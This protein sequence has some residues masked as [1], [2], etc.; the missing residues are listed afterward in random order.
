MRTNATRH[1]FRRLLA[2]PLFSAAALVTL[3]VGIGANTAM[4]SVVY[5]V[6][7][8]PLPFSDPERL[9]G[10]WH[11]AP[12]MGVALANQGPATYVTYREEGRVFE[13][14]G[15]WS[16][17]AVSVTGRGEP[18][19]VRALMVSDGMLPLLGVR[20]HLGRRFTRADDTPGT[21]E[22]VM[23]TFAHWQRTFGGDPAALGRRIREPEGAWR[24]IVGVVADERDDG[25]ALAAPAIVY[26]PMLAADFEGDALRAQRVVSFAVRSTR[27]GSPGFLKDVQQAVWAVNPNLP[28]AN[29]QSL[30]AIR[31]SSMAQTS[32][33]LIMLGLASGVA[34]LAGYLPARRAAALDP[35]VALRADA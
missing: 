26:F 23:L 25:G 30:A 13:D 8:K 35:V 18:E 29:V 4:F 16:T 2:A 12:G 24:E 15:L 11:R 21:P 1:I 7:L 22:T 5:G 34:L 20:P 6:L 19:R 27:T 9:V 33:A 28:L 17:S 32:F 3:A 31:A 10:V 14:I